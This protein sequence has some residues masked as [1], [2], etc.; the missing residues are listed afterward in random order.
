MAGVWIKVCNVHSG[1][2][3]NGAVCPVRLQRYGYELK[4]YIES[5]L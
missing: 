2:K 5:F 3:V 4:A 1:Q